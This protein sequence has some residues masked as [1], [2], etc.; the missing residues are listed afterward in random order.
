MQAFNDL[1]EALGY[2]IESGYRISEADIRVALG[3]AYLANDEPS[4]A[5]AEAERA[6][7]MSVEMGYHWGQV[8]AKEVLEKLS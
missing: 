7:S 8:D 4:K 2:A 1:K 3:W 6:L 5:K